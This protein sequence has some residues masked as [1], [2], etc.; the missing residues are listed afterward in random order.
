M[1]KVRLGAIV[2]AV[3]AATVISASAQTVDHLRIWIQGVELHDD[4]GEQPR[5][6]FAGRGLT[7]GEPVSAAIWK[8]N[9]LC[10]LGGASTLRAPDAEMAWTVEATPIG[11]VDDAVKFRLTWARERD[12]GTSAGTPGGSIDVTLRP[13]ETLPI[14][15]A[16]VLSTGSQAPCPYRRLALRVGVDYYPRSDTDHRMM[17]TDLWLVR[18]LANGSEQSERISVRGQPNRPTPFYFST[19]TDEGVSLDFYGELTVKLRDGP[20]EIALVTR[21]RLIEGG[22]QSQTMPVNVPNAQGRQL[23]GSRMVESTIPFVADEVVSVEL[24]RL[25]ENSSGAFADEAFSITIRS[26][27]VR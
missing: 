22:E 10:A 12:N 5:V 11:V 6:A 9:G 23:F 7:V 25:A 14:D 20:S 1:S 18:Q 17:E 26:R 24:P 19:V 2:L 3:H 21:S 27:Q 16:D 4:G 8:M 13:G 15:I